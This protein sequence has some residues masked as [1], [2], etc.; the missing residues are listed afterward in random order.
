VAAERGEPLWK[1][2][3]DG[4]GGRQGVGE[5]NENERPRKESR[6]KGGGNVVVGRDQSGETGGETQGQSRGQTGGGRKEGETGERN[7]RHKEILSICPS[8]Q[9]TP[10]WLPCSLSKVGEKRA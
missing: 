4:G 7:R 5:A 10:V 9:E 8:V 1:Q 3:A 2:K 6:E